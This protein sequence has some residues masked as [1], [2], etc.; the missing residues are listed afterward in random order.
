MICFECKTEFVGTKCQGWAYNKGKNVYCGPKCISKKN[1]RNM[2]NTNRLYASVRMKINNPMFKEECLNKMK[3]SM[4]GKKFKVRGGNGTGPTVPEK[5]LADALGAK[6]NVAIKT[7]FR[8]VYPTVYKVDLAI[9]EHKI[10]I[11]VDGRS[12]GIKSRKEQDRK[13][14]YLLRSLGWTVL[15]I[16][17]KEVISM[18]G[19]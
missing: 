10:A 1:A 16:T 12:H 14:E 15:R 6:L 5:M 3:K 9:P 11:E 13:K 2:A 7:G 8:K 4:K 19:D 18:L 17:N